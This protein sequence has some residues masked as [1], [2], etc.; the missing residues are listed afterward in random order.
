VSHEPSW[1]DAGGGYS[2]ALH[3]GKLVCRNAKGSVLK[4]VPKDVRDSDVG[5]ALLT[6]RD[7]LERHE[8]ECAEQVDAWMLR[9]LPVPR[10]VLESVWDDPAW[11]APLAHAIVAPL[12]DHEPDLDRAGFLEGA[13]SE[14]GVGVVTIDGE[15]AWIDASELLLPH[16]ILLRDL[17][18][19]RE[20]ATDLGFAQGVQQLFRETF[21]RDAKKH[22]DASTSVSDFAQ[23]KFA[24]LN[25]ALG[26]CRTLGYRVRGGY[27]VCPVLERN[28]SIEARYWIGS[29]YP[30]GETYTGELVWVD[31]RERTL[32]LADVGPVAFSE[33]MRMAS[34][35]YAARVVETGGAS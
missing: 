20:L 18:D 5:Q 12:V 30:E 15:S 23:G 3:D 7:W 9:S 29:D 2:L 25:H 17:N 22:A 14:R 21:D 16:P 19:W 24:Q 1:V 26:K 28:V 27:A 8:R 11:R 32:T 6:L 34:A 4:S 31:G 10:A 13:T 33:G 35:I